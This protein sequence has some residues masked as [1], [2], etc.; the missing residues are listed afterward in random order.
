MGRSVVFELVLDRWQ[1]A[2]QVGSAAGE[3]RY[4]LRL[5]LSS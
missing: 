2:V 1:R 3:S 5:A 4:R